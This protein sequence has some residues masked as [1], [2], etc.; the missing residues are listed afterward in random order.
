MIRDG[1]PDTQGGIACES[2]LRHLLQIH[3]KMLPWES[4]TEGQGE[5]KRE[6]LTGLEQKVEERENVRRN[7]Q[8]IGTKRKRAPGQKARKNNSQKDRGER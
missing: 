3:N 6:R 8:S 5:R 7:S 1:R 2:R 4:R